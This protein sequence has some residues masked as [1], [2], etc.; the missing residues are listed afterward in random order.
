[1][2]AK[3]KL[4]VDKYLWAIRLFKTRSQAA[5]ACDNGKVKLQGTNIKASKSV[6]IGDVF[7]V[8]AEGRK[9]VIRVTGLLE[10]RAAYPEAIKNYEDITPPEELDVVKFQAASFQTGKRLSKVGRPTK[11]DLRDIRGFMGEE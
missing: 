9:W 10:K 8:K 2:E 6:N 11:R 3:E 5:D 7:D 4:R 1:V